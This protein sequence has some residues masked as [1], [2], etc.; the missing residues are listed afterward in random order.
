MGNSCCTTPPND[1]N[2]EIIRENPNLKPQEAASII[3]KKWRQKNMS[4]NMNS[5]SSK[6]DFKLSFND[7]SS[8]QIVTRLP[9]LNEAMASLISKRVRQKLD[10]LKAQ[11]ESPN[12]ELF[13][14]VKFT[15]GVYFK[16]QVSEGDELSYAKLIKEDSSFYYEGIV[17]NNMPN[18]FGVF[19]SSSGEYYIGEWRN[20]KAHGKGKFMSTE[21]TSYNGEWEND[22]QNGEGSEHLKSG[23]KYKGDY[24][25]GL[26]TGKGRF[27]W[28]DGSYYMGSFLDNK[29]TGYGEYSWPDGRLYKGKWDN[30]KMEGYGEFMWPDGRKYCGTYKEGKK[31]GRGK[32]SW[33]NGKFYDGQWKNG[34]KDTS[35]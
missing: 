9:E 26:K 35:V 5:K 19:L 20:G 14:L 25:E 8:Y 29:F 27:D 21:G 15:N 3:Q 16:G 4:T 32:F 34:Q 24:K 1:G 17:K 10:S 12:S 18:G 13:G 2:L 28:S 6:N 31:H 33:P 30:G 11:Y 22:I 23:A 7:E